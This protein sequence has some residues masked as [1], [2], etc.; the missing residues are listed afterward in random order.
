MKLQHDASKEQGQALIVGVKMR[1]VPARSRVFSMAGVGTA[2]RRRPSFDQGVID[3][4]QARIAP[5]LGQSFAV[6]AT[7]FRADNSEERDLRFYLRSRITG[8]AAMT[9][10]R[11]GHLNA[12]FESALDERLSHLDTAHAPFVEIAWL[13]NSRATNVMR[14]QC[15]V[16]H[17]ISFGSWVRGQDAGR[18]ALDD[19]LPTR[20]ICRNPAVL[21]ADCSRC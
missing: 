5:R 9:L 8:N 2:R 11:F 20:L 3:Q 14:G 7:L 17:T 1:F 4:Y 15:R 6:H 21:V 18:I 13:P 16:R 10:G 19:P 12:E